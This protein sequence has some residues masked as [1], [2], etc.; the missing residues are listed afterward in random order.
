MKECKKCGE[1]VDKKWGYVNLCSDYDEPEKINRSRAVI[2]ADGKTDY[3]IKIVHQPTDEEV[4]AIEA[5]GRAH[6]PRT[7]LTAIDKVSK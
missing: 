1:P 5:A 4:A 7:H 6:D 3:Y 2:I